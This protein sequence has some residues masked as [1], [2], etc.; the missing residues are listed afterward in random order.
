[1][2]SLAHLLTDTTVRNA[3]PL[4]LSTVLG[5]GQI[6]DQAPIVLRDNIKTYWLVVLPKHTREFRL[7]SCKGF[8][9]LFYKACPSLLSVPTVPTAPKIVSPKCLPIRG[10]GAIE[11]FQY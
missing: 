8:P 1:M 11:Y 7:R 4:V 10:G 5:L 2:N 3:Q 9:E 6:W